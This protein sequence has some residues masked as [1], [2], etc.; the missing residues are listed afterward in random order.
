[1]AEKDFAMQYRFVKHIGSHGVEDA[2]VATSRT[3]FFARLQ[4][5]LDL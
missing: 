1:M 5:H 3:Y 4:T 2:W